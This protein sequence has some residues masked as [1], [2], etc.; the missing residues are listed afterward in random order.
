MAK[1]GGEYATRAS[2]PA[3]TDAGRRSPAVVIRDL[4][5]RFARDNPTWGHRR[6]HGELVGLG[7]RSPQ[8]RSGTSSTTRDLTL[9][10]AVLVLCVPKISSAS[11]GDCVFV[12]FAADAGVPS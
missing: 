1:R 3:E 2:P 12:D 7:Y 8:L 6:I 5:I 4:A 10:D 11:C 9:R